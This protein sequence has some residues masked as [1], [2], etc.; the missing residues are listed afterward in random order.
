MAHIFSEHYEK[1]KR[2]GSTSLVQPPMMLFGDNDV[3]HGRK[4]NVKR[5]HYA[6]QAKVMGPYDRSLAYGIITMFYKL[7]VDKDEF[8]KL[9]DKQFKVLQKHLLTGNDVIVPKP[10]GKDVSQNQNRYCDNGKQIIF[11]NLGTGIAQLPFGYIEYIQY[12]IDELQKYARGAKTVKYY[13]YSKVKSSKQIV[14]IE[15]R[16]KNNN[17]PKIYE[18]S[19]C[20]DKVHY[21]MKYKNCQHD[22]CEGCL[23]GLIVEH[24]NY[25]DNIEEDYRFKCWVA[26]TGKCP[27][28]IICLEDVNIP[29]DKCYCD[30][31]KHK[32]T[33]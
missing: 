21:L 14:N 27:N 31:C 23:A 26:K 17:D 5:L 8:M 28:G 18:C 11:H 2:V 7:K 20:K 25:A 13:R 12:K 3:D 15:S 32:N 29:N 9:M 33:D 19:W 1:Y 24:L 4:Y 16:I 22:S 30:Y 6:G 10:T